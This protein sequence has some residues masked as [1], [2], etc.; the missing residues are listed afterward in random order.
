M[1]SNDSPAPHSPVVSSDHEVEAELSE[2]IAAIVDRVSQEAFP[3]VLPSEQTVMEVDVASELLAWVQ[4]VDATEIQSFMDEQWRL[5]RQ[6]NIVT[7][8]KPDPAR[9]AEWARE[10]YY[11][12]LRQFQ[13]SRQQ[14]NLVF[15]SLKACFPNAVIS[16]GSEAR[17]SE[18]CLCVEAANIEALSQHVAEAWSAIWTSL[19]EFCR[20]N[21]SEMKNEWFARSCV[22]LLQSFVNAQARSQ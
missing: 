16:A 9:R 8:E 7:D 21:E 15:E 14:Q 4:K 5:F 11:V 6:N 19:P 13:E 17:I 3:A 12:H 10:F 1:A 18:L 22:D 2:S 20:I